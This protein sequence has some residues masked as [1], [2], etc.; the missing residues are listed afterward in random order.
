MNEV[1]NAFIK[2]KMNKDLDSRLIPSGEYRHAQN[3]QVSKSEGSDVG[4]LEN[5]LGN[6]LVADLTDGNPNVNSIGYFADNTTSVVYVFLTDNNNASGAYDPNAVNIIFKYDINLNKATKLVEGAFLNFHK[7]YPIFGVNLLENLLFWT[8]NRNQHRKIN[9]DKTLG[10]YTTEDHISV[11]KFYPFKS[12]DLFR[13]S[14]LAALNYETTMQDVVSKNLPNGGSATISAAVVNSNTFDISNLNIPVTPNTLEQG[15]TVSYIDANGD[16]VDTNETISSFTDPTVTLTGN[17]NIPLTT[18][19]T[20]IIFNANP[21]YDKNY[22]GDISFIEDKFV[23]FSYRFK[24]DDGEYSLVAPFTQS[25]FIPKQDGYFLNKDQ[26]IV[27]P[28]ASAT[29]DELQAIQS[30][31]VKFMENKVNKIYLQIPL[32]TTKSNFNSSFHV[33]E[34]DIILKESDGLALQVLDTIEVDQNFTG[35]EN[36]LEYEYLGKKPYKTLQSN[37]VTRVYDKVPLKALAQEIISNRVVYGN[38]IN[39]P[40]PPSFLN[41]NVSATEKYDFNLNENRTSVVEYPSSSLKTNREYQVGFVLADRYGRQSSVI[42]SNNKDAITVG[43]TTY[44][45]SSLFSPYIDQN[46]GDNID[47]WFGNSLKILLN[48]PIPSGITGIYNDDINSPNYNPTGWYSYKIVVKQNEQEYYNVYA[49][50]AVKGNPFNNTVDLNNTYISLESDNI[51]KVPRDLSEVGPDQKQYRSSVRLYPRVNILNR[52]NLNQGDDNIQFYPG[53]NFF[54]VDSIQDMYD[55]FNIERFD[56]TVSTSELYMFQN[57]KSNPLLARVTTSS[58]PNEQFGIIADDPLSSGSMKNL[59]VLET[60]PVVSRLDIFWETS[61]SGIIKDLNESV[62][63]NNYVTDF[64]SSFD[65]TFF[66]ESLDVDDNIFN[67]SFT[68]VNSI[69][70]NITPGWITSFTLDYVKNTQSTPLDVSSYFTFYEVDPSGNPGFYNI[71]VTNDFV[72][73]IFYGSDVSKRE[74]D[75]RFSIT[76]TEPGQQPVTSIVDK[77]L[78]LTND[79]PTMTPNQTLNIDTD[80]STANLTTLTSV[81]GASTNSPNKGKDISWFIQ[82][83][84]GANSGTVNYFRVSFSNTDSLSTCILQNNNVGNLPADI[85]TVVVKTEDAGGLTDSI[86]IT[87]NN[88]VEIGTVTEYTFT[89]SSGGLPQEYNFVVIE[90][91]GASDPSL[92]GYYAYIGTWSMLSFGFTVEIDNTNS[93]G[94]GSC[95]SPLNGGW[96]LGS[97]N[98]VVVSQATDCLVPGFSGLVTSDN[99]DTRGYVFTIV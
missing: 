50:G 8:D 26:D 34:I 72:N 42:L 44:T 55:T 11:A 28:D 63:G 97:N 79:A 91:T 83:Q 6:S 56:A 40:T 16:I 39:K 41:Y 19:V 2:S 81:N 14:P 3:S 27:G 98:N 5:I 62:A 33:Q 85:Y 13:E 77:I 76:I 9:V 89:D 23:R 47:S 95:P 65:N 18:T 24:F 93:V 75:F 35:T 96:I 31:I 80:G 92:E 64:S 43:N 10:Y 68:P 73:N 36:V 25:C 53:N 87:I 49:A 71:K 61:T 52:L 7:S 67:A 32:P 21:Y 38:Y 22:S 51:N 29:G 74:F 46:V 88:S 48:D 20:Q 54:T 84:S 59:V 99:P 82:S 30:T 15:F 57:A 94:Q 66:S 4:S 78:S 1:K 60:N 69:G 12:I 17:V 58:D 37:E 90:V 45:G 70:A 86:T